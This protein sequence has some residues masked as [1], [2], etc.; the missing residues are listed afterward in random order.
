MSAEDRQKG[1]ER[2]N[3]IIETLLMSYEKVIKYIDINNRP[4]DGMRYFRYLWDIDLCNNNIS[5]L[6]GYGMELAKYKNSIQHGTPEA[7]EIISTKI[8][9]D[10]VINILSRMH[11]IDFSVGILKAFVEEIQHKKVAEVLST[12][13]VPDHLPTTEHNP[14]KKKL[15]ASTD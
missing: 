2:L 13:P 8:L 7:L 5:K 15:K 4:T 12:L 11:S 3:E 10:R 6:K 9:V 1:Y 14:N